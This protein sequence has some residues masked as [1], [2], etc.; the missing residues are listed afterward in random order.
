MVQVTSAPAAQAAQTACT[1]DSGFTTCVAYTYSG[2]DQT[3]T[4]PTGVTSVNIKAWGAGGGGANSAY[5]TNQAGGASGAYVSGTLATTAGQSLLVVV[6]QGGTVGDSIGGSLTST[7]GGG[8]AGGN[9][10]GN[11]TGNSDTI[12]D[13]SAGG[14][15][16]GVFLTSKTAA[17]ARLIAA[18]GGGSS[19]GSD[20]GAPFPGGG[21]GLVGLADTVT[22]QSG[23]GG[24]ATA[25][26]AAATSTAGCAAAAVAGAQFQGG[27]GSSVAT[28]AI[29]PYRLR[30]WRRRWRWLLRRWRRKVPRQCQPAGPTTTGTAAG[31]PASPAVPA[32][33]PRAAPPETAARLGPPVATAR[34]YRPRRRSTRPRPGSA[35]A[36]GSRPRRR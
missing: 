14:G 31:V 15:L 24:T 23:R 25:G 12:A 33:P 27:A 13:G 28:N 18:G 1:P 9:E 2:A 3:F 17:N 22:A 16:S 29:D 5:K 35:K 36:A 30:G 32:S 8:G 6:G 10:T 11:T 26:G 21:G 20:V 7:Y 34:R 4:V 19:P